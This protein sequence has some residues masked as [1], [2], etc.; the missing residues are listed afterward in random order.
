MTIIAC[1][2]PFHLFDLWPMLGMLPFA[3]T[4]LRSWMARR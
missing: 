3:V 1:A 4:R 2:A